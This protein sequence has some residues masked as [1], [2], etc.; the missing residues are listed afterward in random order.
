MLGLVPG[1]TTKN[2]HRGA[3]MNKRDVYSQSYEFK[4][5]V[6]ENKKVQFPYI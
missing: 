6:V 1:H 2:K 4:T 3:R 5:A